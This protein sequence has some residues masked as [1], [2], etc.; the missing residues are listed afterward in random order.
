MHTVPVRASTL[1][2]GFKQD[3]TNT[4]NHNVGHLQIQGS[5]TEYN[6]RQNMSIT[7]SSNWSANTIGNATTPN[8]VIAIA[9]NTLDD[10]GQ[11]LWNSSLPECYIQAAFSSILIAQYT[12][13]AKNITANSFQE[14]NINIPRVNGEKVIPI[15]VGEYRSGK[16]CSIKIKQ[17]DLTG[18]TG[19]I[20]FDY[21]NLTNETFTNARP[22]IYYI[23]VANP[24]P[25]D[26]Q[27]LYPDYIV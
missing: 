8:P 18:L 14:W 16:A 25:S 6:D 24:I 9:W 19:G 21:Y 12:T 27:S 4:D 10:S 13:P 23:R 3:T 11:P 1:N 20:I 26:K 15:F 2:F 7:L 22:V 17:I 5:S